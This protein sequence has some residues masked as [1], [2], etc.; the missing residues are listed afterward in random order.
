MI[1]MG[2]FGSVVAFAP[3]TETCQKCPVR[4]CC[5]AEV[6]KKEESTLLAIER[7]ETER[8]TDDA[9]LFKKQRYKIDDLPNAAYHK[10]KRFF[11]RRKSYTQKRARGEPVS[12]AEK[13]YQKM[14]ENGIKF[15]VIRSGGNPFKDGTFYPFMAH[16][17]DCLHELQFIT[18]KDVQGHFAKIGFGT[19]D[20]GR[21]TM[22][23]RALKILELAKVAKNENQEG[24]YCLS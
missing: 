17:V 2:C 23:R 14:V 12:R 18:A 16:T 11:Q 4:E 5:A 9:T 21:I 7:K 3:K 15:E 10:V 6:F 24:T 13:D 19:S 1:K 8:E 22:A 20:G